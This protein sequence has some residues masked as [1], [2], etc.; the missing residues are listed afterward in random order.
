MI[1]GRELMLQLGLPADF[2]HQGLQWGSDTV[3]V[4][5]P[6][7]MLGKSDLNKHYIHEVVMHTAV[8]ASTREATEIFLKYHLQYLCKIRL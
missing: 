5:E 3:P 8:P 7:G 6:S 2:N 4:K 1:K